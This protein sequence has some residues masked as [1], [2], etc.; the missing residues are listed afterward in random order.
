L[1]KIVR[2]PAG[3]DFAQPAEARSL[4]E[5]EGSISRMSVIEEATKGKRSLLLSNKIPDF[6]KKKG[7]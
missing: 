2:S 4:R 7:I 1:N 6:L 3:F 5:V